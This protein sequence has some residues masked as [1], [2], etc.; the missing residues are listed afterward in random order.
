MLSVVV[1][2]WGSSFALLKLGL[3]EIT[4]INLAFLRFLVVL[5]FFVI[6]TV[7]KDKHAFVRSIFRDWKILLALGVTG[8]TLYHVFQNLGLRFTTASN[9]S[10]IISANPI[11]IAL[12]DHFYLK[13]KMTLKRVSGIVLAFVG[14]IL[15][16][17]PLRL[18]FDPMGMIG[19]LLSLGAGLS[20][21]FYTVLGKKFLS[22]YGAQRVTAFSIIFGT[23]FLLPILLLTEK[24]IVPTSLWLWFLLLILS[25]LCSGLAYF[26]WYKALEEVSATKVAIFL[27]FL[28]VVSVS[29][30]SLLLSETLEISLVAG[31]FFVILGVVVTERS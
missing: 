28:P 11:F 7:S 27:F 29:V 5:P 16:I 13:E 23:L 12:L 15:I 18:T 6:F 4:P 9:S 25:L 14:V 8:V 10:L 24:P 26:F 31:A 22:S 3:E 17:G 1:F 20:W 2:L 19:D 21:A 30:A